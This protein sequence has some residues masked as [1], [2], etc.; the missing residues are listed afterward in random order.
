MTYTQLVQS[1]KDWTANSESTFAGEIDFIIELA[2]K[3]IFRDSDLN[4]ARKSSTATLSAGDEFLS[5][6]A[7]AQVI[8]SIQT[9]DSSGDRI[10]LLQ[11]DKSFLDDYIVDRSTTGSPRYYSHWDD[12]TVYVVPSPV[13]D[14]TIEIEYTRRPDGLS[15]SVATTWVSTEAPDALL[16]ACLIEASLFMKGA[17]DLTQSYTTKYQEALQRL[18]M[19]ENLRNRTD[20]YRTRS[21][22]LGEA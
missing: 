8:K 11:K 1:I 10:L 21:I 16:Y 9:V 14:T 22:T 6:P 2:E 5:K 13:A 19:E 17:P 15:S 20:E 3:R 18:I 12:D 7:G 4:V